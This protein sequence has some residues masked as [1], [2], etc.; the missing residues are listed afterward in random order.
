MSLASKI[1]KSV[2]LALN[3]FFSIKDKLLG[4]V[5]NKIINS[6]NVKNLVIDYKN[7][8][9]AG[10]GGAIV[11]YTISV[12]DDILLQNN[13]NKGQ[14][15]LVS[16][17]AFNNILSCGEVICTDFCGSVA[18]TIRF[19][20]QAG[21]QS[22][23][24]ANISEDSEGTDYKQNTQNNF[25]LNVNP[26]IFTSRSAVL[27]T[28]DGQRTMCTAIDSLNYID[29]DDI[30]LKTQLSLSSC[31]F[32]IIEGYL[33]FNKL[34]MESINAI[35]HVAKLNG[36]EV[37]MSLSDAF[38]VTSCFSQMI[39]IINKYCS[40]VFGNKDEFDALS[41]Q[42]AS[43]KISFTNN[44]TFVITNGSEGCCIYKSEDYNLQ[45]GFATS[46]CKFGTEPIL[47]PVD[48]T[49]AGDIFMG[50][51]IYGLIKNLNLAECV[52]LAN[53][54]AAKVIMQNGTNMLNKI[55]LG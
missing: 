4:K 36:V 17:D 38:C 1:A 54:N 5:T 39:E 16:L 28:P 12:T 40:F 49:G 32:L 53:K 37:V 6:G 3:L 9:C 29:F 42:L 19:L 34:N 20:N 55:L 35:C 44:I 50:G 15:H 18:N 45:H 8:E 41:K 14:M 22:C 30:S 10:L 23:L 33:F 43:C 31:K 7:I 13:L 25:A 11:D 24:I 46:L 21:V 51:F 48:T 27:I 47:N 2:K 52:N 26:A